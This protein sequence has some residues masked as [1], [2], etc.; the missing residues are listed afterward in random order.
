MFDLV[1][2]TTRGCEFPP[3]TRY[4]DNDVEDY[5]YSDERL[6]VGDDADGDR[7]MKEARSSTQPRLSRPSV[8]LPGGS[9]LPLIQ[10]SET[11]GSVDDFDRRDEVGQV[12]SDE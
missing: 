12:S 11:D 4:K 1:S 10:D 3:P 6:A 5:H 9:E 8:V 7:R 2:V